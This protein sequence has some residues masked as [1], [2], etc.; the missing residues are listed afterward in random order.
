MI[1]TIREALKEMQKLGHKVIKTPYGDASDMTYLLSTEALSLLDTL[2]VIDGLDEA[3]ETRI[4]RHT[5]MDTFIKTSNIIQEAAQAYA[6]LMGDD[7]PDQL[8]QNYA[9]RYADQVLRDYKAETVAWLEGEAVR[10]IGYHERNHNEKKGWNA[11]ID[12]VIAK[13]KEN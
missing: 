11:A 7:K 12:S 9:H 10:V 2:P 6:K 5:D 13:L 8:E 4:E 1:K 3:L